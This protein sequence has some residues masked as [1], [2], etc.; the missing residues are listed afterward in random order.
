VSKPAQRSFGLFEV[1]HKTDKRERAMR[2]FDRIACMSWGK[3]V[4]HVLLY[5]ICVSQ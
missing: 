4:Q 2:L 5:N 1:E 3:H